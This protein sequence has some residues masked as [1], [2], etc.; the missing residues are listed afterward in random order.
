MNVSFEQLTAEQAEEIAKWRYES[1]Y[2]LYDY[3][4]QPVDDVIHY[5]SDPAKR[6]FAVLRDRELIGFRSFGADGRVPGGKYE[7]GYLDTGGGLRPDLTGRGMGERIL[8]SGIEF[9]AE[10]FGT[11]RF[12]VTVAEFN[13]RALKVCKRVGFEEQNRFNRRDDVCFVILVLDCQV[14]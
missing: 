4:D 8:K 11:N 5:L 13:E 1:P 9:G 14:S 2:Q 10:K 6:F 12:R 3:R 7:G